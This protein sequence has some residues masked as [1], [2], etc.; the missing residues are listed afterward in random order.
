MILILWMTWS[1]NPNAIMLME[2]WPSRC[3][4][5]CTQENGGGQLRYEL[6]CLISLGRTYIMLKKKVQTE[7]HQKHITIIP[8][9]ISSD[10]TQLTTFR[11][12]Q[13]YPVYLTIGNLPKHIHRKPS[14]QGQVLLA[15]LY[16]A[17]IFHMESM[18]NRFIPCG[19]HGIYM[20]STW[21]PHGICFTT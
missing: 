5:T 14:Q 4:M 6:P 7:T 21:N 8:I 10:K 15:I 2:I 17:P 11:G 20:E 1:L 9:I 13:A 12:K 3:T 18:W 16:H 19:I